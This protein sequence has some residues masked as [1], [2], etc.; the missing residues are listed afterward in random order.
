[1]SAAP[2]T[3]DDPPQPWLVE[4]WQRAEGLIAALVRDLEHLRAEV[5]VR[6]GE[7]ADVQQALSILDGRTQR[8]ETGY[9]LALAVRQELAALAEQL[10]EETALRRDHTAAQERER[11]RSRN[12]LR[13]LA[14]S[15]LT[16]SD[17]L[18]AVEGAFASERERQRASADEGLTR[19]RAH[20]EIA[21]RLDTLDRQ[22]DALRTQSRRDA[23]ERAQLA[24]RAPD[25]EP[26]LREMVTRIHVL[27]QEQQRLGDEVAALRSTRDHEAQLMDLLEQQRVSRQ[28]I[29]QR[30]A[31]LDARQVEL[32][33]AIDA[34]AEQRRLLRHELTGMRHEQRTQG[35][36]MEGQRI[37][38]LE[39]LRR[40]TVTHEA[41]V[42]RQAEEMD[43]Q[44]RAEREL[45]VRLIEES[46]AADREQPL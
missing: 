39:H 10:A 29:E 28:R 2:P 44:L 36:S 30:F 17:R 7:A 27:Q 20:Q 25:V 37:S 5:Q 14:E 26:L 33:G 22:L 1:M 35:E 15:M 16:L 42:R 23:E 9:D 41:A 31:E 32:S 18:N 13:D 6:H 3:R 11:G 4:R 46:Q 40:V 24:G 8:H 38:I 43:R 19:E 45:L 34:D 21:A 12:E